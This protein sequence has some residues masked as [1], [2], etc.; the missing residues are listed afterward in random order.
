MYLKGALSQEAL[1]LIDNISITNENYTVA[2]EI[3]KKRPIDLRLRKNEAILTESFKSYLHDETGIKL[4][5]ATP[6]DCH[7]LHEDPDLVAALSICSPKTVHGLIFTDNATLEIQ[8]LTPKLR[9][10]SKRSASKKDVVPHIVKRAKF[11]SDFLVDDLFPIAGSIWSQKE[12][13]LASSI[14]DVLDKE[15]FEENSGNFQARAQ[16]L[17]V[18]LALFF[19]EAAYKIFAPYF[20]YDEKKLQNMLLAYVNGVQA[21]YHHPSLGK[22]LELVLVRLDIMKRQP[23]E[24]PHYSGERSQLLDSFCEYQASINPK[25]DSDPEHWDMGLYISGL[26][27]FAYENGRKSGVTM[28][29][30]TVGGVCLEK[31]A[32]I[33]A[34]FGTTNVFGKPYPSAGFT[35]VY[36]LAHEIGHNLG[37]HHDSS[38]NGCSK[39]GYIMSPSRGTNGE[40][41]WSTCSAQIVAKLDWAKCLKDVAKPLRG[42][43]HSRFLD[44]PGRIY[45]SKKQCEILLRDKDAVMSPSQKQSDVCY[46]LQCKTPNRSGYYSAGP[47]LDG[48]PCGSGKYCYG[49]HCSSKQPPRPV[50]VISGGW[51]KWREGTCTSGCIEGSKGIKISSRECNNPP[52]QN[53]DQGCEGSNKQVNICADTNLCH[54]K[55]KTPVEFASQKCQEFSRL[56]PELDPTGVG[57]QAPHEEGRVWTSCAIFCKRKDSAAFYTPRIELNDLGVSAYFPEG[58]WCHKDSAGMNYFCMQRHCLPEVF[59]FSKNPIGI[60]DDIPFAQNARPNK[61]IIPAHLKNYFAL[62]PNGRPILTSFKSVGSQFTDDKEE[63]E[64]KDYVELPS[65]EKRFQSLMQE[66]ND[67][68]VF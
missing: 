21:L 54:G 19:D 65:V 8:P 64:T 10:I 13:T 46:S 11:T 28:G 56:L 57:L 68:D 60:L 14:E 30:A 62:S 53:T 32:C 41:Q 50:K 12:A 37:M 47:A 15:I 39:E 20:G 35:S 23:R 67:L 5:N 2:L 4:L 33:I 31:Y 7:Y 27:F 66:V 45:T 6:S 26:D 22:S 43:D 48:T 29:L 42:K 44:I 24:M 9:R 36:I 18:E 49:G 55:R 16:T 58:T 59:K 25:S 1:N 38:G 17:T 34:E 51:S 63:W 40:T 3:L 61:P 52:P